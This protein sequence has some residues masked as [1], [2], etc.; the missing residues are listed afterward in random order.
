MIEGLV[1]LGRPLLEGKLPPGEVIK[2]ISDVAADN[3]RN[4]L[5]HVFVVEIERDDRGG[6]VPDDGAA[7]FAAK[8]LPVQQWGN[9]VAAGARAR[10]QVFVPDVNRAVAAPFVLPKGGSPRVPQGRYGVPVYPVYEDGLKE[11]REANGTDAIRR[12]LSGRLALTSDHALS[13]SEIANVAREL[14]GAIRSASLDAPGK[15]L[16]LVVLADVSADGPYGL[17]DAMP[18]GIPGLGYVG[19]SVLTPGKHLIARLERVLELWWRARVEEGADGGERTGGDAQCFFCGSEGRVVS[20]YCKAWPWLSP[21]WNCPLPVSWVPRRRRYR[22]LVE[23]IAVCP[24]CCRALSYGANVFMKL[25]ASFD[26]WLTREIFSPVASAGGRH[27][28]RSSGRV[29]PIQGSAIILPLVDE[30]LTDDVA[31]QEFVEGV[32]HMLH[33]RPEA[34]RLDTHL[35]SITGFEMMLPE[36]LAHEDY[37]LYLTYFTGDPSRGDIHLRST[38]EDVVPSTARKLVH[39]VGALGD[40]ALDVARRLS[41]VEASE[42]Q[43]A[44]MRRTYTSLPYLLATAFGAPFLW[45]T[46]ATV[47]HRGS[48]SSERFIMNSAARMTQLAHRLPDTHFQLNDEIVFYLTFRQFLR[49]YN[50]DIQTNREGGGESVRDWRVLEEMLSSGPA[51]AMTFQDAEEIGFACGHLTGL[52]SRQYW[53]AT[54]V[55]REGRDFLKQRVMTFGTDLTPSTIYTRGLARMEEFARRLDMHLSEDFRR[56]LAVVLVSFARMRDEV[57][58]GRHA[59]MAAFWAGH[60]LAGAPG[61]V[62]S[63]ERIGETRKEGTR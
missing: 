61:A 9:Y 59:F 30:F 15:V 24:D 11:F 6:R 33:R 26:M 62:G 8:A 44:F 47:L 20:P 38:I 12:F 49:A 10:K 17:S 57:S 5:A 55:G 27:T 4:F 63:N 43:A 19:P 52:F 1:R 53:H 21:T 45:D 14:G 40:Y 22:D 32:N 2:Q 50:K 58:R 34:D 13:D 60:N 29:E 42:Q 28:A 48:V 31:K 51:E 25:S 56:R 36:E 41:R 3:A 35:K 18:V 37:R 16:A 46:L 39:L 23:G 54:K 7:A